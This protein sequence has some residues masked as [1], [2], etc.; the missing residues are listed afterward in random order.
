[1]I[2]SKRSFKKAEIQTNTI[3]LTAEWYC[4]LFATSD[5]YHPYIRSHI[6]PKQYAV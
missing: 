2:L 5:S 1:M 4:K 6:F 3:L